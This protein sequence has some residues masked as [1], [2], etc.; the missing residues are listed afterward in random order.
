MCRVTDDCLL[1]PAFPLAVT[2]GASL[3]VL[4]SAV[5]AVALVVFLAKSA[6][7]GYKSLS[8]SLL[9]YRPTL[10]G[11]GHLALLSIP[12]VG[13]IIFNILL[14]CDVSGFK[15]GLVSEWMKPFFTCLKEQFCF[16]REC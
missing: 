13:S 12:V 4:A 10:I 11:A 7:I 14:A 8:D 5:A 16:C 1:I 6:W 3:M 9:D 2:V 15:E